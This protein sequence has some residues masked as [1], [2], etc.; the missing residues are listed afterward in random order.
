MRCCLLPLAL[1]GLLAFPAHADE[2]A[3]IIDGYGDYRWDS[4]L[5]FPAPGDDSFVQIPNSGFAG[6]KF[7]DALATDYFSFP[8][9]GGV[10]SVDGKPG[11]I[12]LKLNPTGIRDLNALGSAVKQLRNMLRTK[13]EGCQIE[14]DQFNFSSNGSSRTYWSG[15][16][17]IVDELG[18]R[19]MLDWHS[20]NLMI[21]YTSAA[22]WRAI[23]DE[24]KN[25]ASATADKL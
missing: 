12:I 10:F 11:L 4:V 17:I 14:Y 15:K 22:G 9:N 21:Q 16:L 20:Y 6:L 25:R 24:E 5:S 19:V 2:A 3:P 23:L 13:Y 18:G 1:V 8:V 7:T